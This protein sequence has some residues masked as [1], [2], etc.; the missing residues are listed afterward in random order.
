MKFV[1]ISTHRTPN[2]EIF[3]QSAKYHDISFD[4][5]GEGQRYTGHACKT[6]WLIDYLADL[7][8]GEIVLYTDS[9]DAF[10][11]AGE[12]EILRKYQKRNVPLLFSAEQNLNQDGGMFQKWSVYQGLQKGVKPYQYLNAGGYIGR[13]GYIR[14]LLEKTL[15][16]E[17]SDQ[18]SF[19][20]YFAQ[21][22]E[23]LHLDDE[24][25]IFSC[26][27]GRTGLETLHYRAKNDR[28]VNK[29]TGAKPCIIHFAAKNFRGANIL[30]SQISYLQE[31]RYDERE[32]PQYNWYKFKNR[33][34]DLSCQDNYLF[35]LTIHSSAV[36]AAIIVLCYF[37]LQQFG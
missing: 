24:N 34:I 7:D 20:T 13:A 30:L 17:V 32:Q 9:Y 22:G 35:H 8:S 21:S 2:F 5:L 33:L 26:T 29:H 16:W 6:S 1:T 36:L 11:L 3:E 28:L 19:N 4:I 14:K 18:S 37:L 25:E 23:A 12:D 15:D 10:F 27:A 31:R